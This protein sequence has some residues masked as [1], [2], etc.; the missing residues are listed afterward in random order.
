MTEIKEKESVEERETP[1]R[2]AETEKDPVEAPQK[3][4][5][6][7]K[8]RPSKRALAKKKAPGKPGRPPGTAAI[9]NEYKA[10]MLNSPKSEKV[11]AAIFD[12][13]LDNEHKNQAAAWKLLMD[14]MLPVKAFEEDVVK[15]SSGNK[16]SINISG[17]GGDVSVQGEKENTEEDEAI[18]ATFTT[19]GEVD[20]DS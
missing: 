4:S 11:L 1:E 16:I 18:D 6:R 15:N 12:A 17:I 14:R 19:V 10:R 20:S 5:Q 9:I 8:G 13:A 2:G 3:P 7:R